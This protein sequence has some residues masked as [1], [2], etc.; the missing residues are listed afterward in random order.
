MHW[1]ISALV[2]WCTVGVLVHWCTGALYWCTVKKGCF[3]HMGNLKS[4]TMKNFTHFESGTLRI[5]FVFGY[6]ILKLFAQN[7]EIEKYYEPFKIIFITSEQ[8]SGFQYR[9]TVHKT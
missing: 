2:Y 1:C 6:T 7:V 8:T 9:P 3:L 5:L 4:V